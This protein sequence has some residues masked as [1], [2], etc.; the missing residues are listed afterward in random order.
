MQITTKSR[1][2]LRAMVEL[3]VNFEEGPLS[4]KEIAEEQKIS[5][6]YLEQ[7]IPFLKSA[8]FV[9]SIQGS[10]GGYVL[11]KDPG[12]ITLLEILQVLEGQLKLVDCVDDPEICERKKQCVTRDLWVEISEE[13]AELL[14]SKSLDQ[15]AEK[16]DKEYRKA[17]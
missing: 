10:K 15:L 8:G 5:Y 2:G 12:S 14:G 6:K 17:S 7:I 9:R 4:L 3:A 1:Y 11:T 13:I 16:R